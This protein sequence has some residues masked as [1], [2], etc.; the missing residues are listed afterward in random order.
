MILFTM[1][2]VTV[3]W[4]ETQPLHARLAVVQRCIGVFCCT[5]KCSGMQ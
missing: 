4:L 5:H 3:T 1:V 2:L